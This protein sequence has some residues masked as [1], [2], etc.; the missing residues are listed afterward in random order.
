M[1]L[2]SKGA[3][4]TEVRVDEHPERRPEMEAR[5]GGRVTVPQI[6]VDDFHVGGY[7]DMTALNARGYLDALLQ[8]G[9]P[10]AENV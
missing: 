1:L 4:F 5:S 8:G 6:F 10:A 7:D 3:E 9:S 2:K